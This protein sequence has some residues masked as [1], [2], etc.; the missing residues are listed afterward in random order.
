MDISYTYQ[1]K[2]PIKVEKYGSVKGIS[3]LVEILLKRKAYE[4]KC[5][6]NTSQQ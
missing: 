4:G 1:S 2:P 6:K 3:K 5:Y